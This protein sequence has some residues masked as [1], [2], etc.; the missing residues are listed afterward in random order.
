MLT[1]AS[2][3]LWPSC[4]KLKKLSVQTI[5]AP[6]SLVNF[7]PHKRCNFMIGATTAESSYVKIVGSCPFLMWRYGMTQKTSSIRS[8]TKINSKKLL[9]IPVGKTKKDTVIRYIY[10]VSLSY[11]HFIHF[12]ISLLSQLLQTKLL[13]LLPLKIVLGPTMLLTYRL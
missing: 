3:D 8:N 11:R 6:G 10:A 9:F 5:L 2:Y 4:H 1:S 12:L 7:Y 13:P